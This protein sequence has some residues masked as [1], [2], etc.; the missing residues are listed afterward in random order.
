[1]KFWSSYRGCFR[2]IQDS[3]EG[4]WRKFER[5]L[6]ECFSSCTWDSLSWTQ[7]PGT[8]GTALFPQ[9]LWGPHRCQKPIS[10]LSA[11]LAPYCRTR[12][13]KQ[14][15]SHR[16]SMCVCP[17]HQVLNQPVNASLHHLLLFWYTDLA[18]SSQSVVSS[19]IQGLDGSGGVRKGSYSMYC[20]V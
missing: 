18:S 3:P 17:C 5:D 14:H 10:L 2:S 1:M 15:I 8:W 6:C 4:F 19:E 16:W 13:K 12:H 9:D 11:G 7:T 20:S